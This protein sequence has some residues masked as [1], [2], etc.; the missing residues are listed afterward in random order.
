MNRRGV[1]L[2]ELLIA[3]SLLALLSLGMLMALRV[4]LAAMEKTNAKLIANRR[5]ASA[6]RILASQVAG[7]VPAMVECQPAPN[8]PPVRLPLFQGEPHAMRLVSTYSLEEAL[9][10][11]PR[12]LEFHVAPGENGSGVRLLVNELVYGGP[13]STGAL[14][15]GVA[16][17]PATGLQ[18]PVYR[19]IGATERSFVLAD[20]LAFCRFQYREAL[21]APEL[22]RWTP[23]WKRPLWPSAVRIEMGQLEPD[24]TRV[25]LIGATLAIPV[26][27]LPYVGYKD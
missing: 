25:P 3:V 16:A 20:K 22:E 23:E 4:G 10:G 11:A 18:L 13:R 2:I 14:C 6:Q 21:P 9:R 5:A 8:E 17:D 15:A 1:T 19:P 24:P 7:L 12:I 26:N 27:R